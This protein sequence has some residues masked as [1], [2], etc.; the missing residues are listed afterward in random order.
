MTT[1]SP[2]TLIDT[3]ADRASGKI[4]SGNPGVPQEVTEIWTFRRQ[5]G[6]APGD[7]RLSA[8]QQG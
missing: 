6:G 8:I 5:I 7:W 3:M 2:Y 4:V 1:S